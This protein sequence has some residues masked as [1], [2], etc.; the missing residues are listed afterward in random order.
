M[1][2]SSGYHL[3]NCLDEKW[4][5]KLLKIDLIG[6]GLMIFGITLGAVY[7]GFHNWDHE[8]R[9]VMFLMATLMILNLGL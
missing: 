8:R 9:Y 5:Y 1:G 7:V 2:A 4:Y 6:I 3:F